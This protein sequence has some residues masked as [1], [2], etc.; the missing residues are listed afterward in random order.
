MLFRIQVKSNIPELTTALSL[1][2]IL[3]AKKF[4]IS[5]PFGAS[6]RLLDTYLR[7]KFNKGLIECCL[8]IL[9]NLTK[10]TSMANEVIYTLV[11]EQ[12]DTLAQLITCGIGET[13]GSRIL[14]DSI[15]HIYK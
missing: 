1:R 9:Y 5:Y 8:S 2:N 7:T 11:D 6:E 12:L 4:I 3:S 14:V 10:S 13:P 15:S